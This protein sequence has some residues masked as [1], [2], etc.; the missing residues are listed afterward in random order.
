MRNTAAKLPFHD[1]SL[2]FTTDHT[3][4]GDGTVIRRISA[5]WT[6]RDDGVITDVRHMETLDMPLISDD[7]VPARGWHY[8]QLPGEGVSGK[9]LWLTSGG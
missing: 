7:M 3:S 8:A 9:R 6:P 2:H 5:R 1:P 4:F